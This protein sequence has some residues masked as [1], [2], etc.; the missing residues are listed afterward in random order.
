MEWRSRNGKIRHKTKWSEEAKRRRGEER[1][2]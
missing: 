2:I 1:G